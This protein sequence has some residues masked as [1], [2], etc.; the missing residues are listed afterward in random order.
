MNTRIRDF[1]LMNYATAQYIRKATPE[2]FASS[3]AA[4]WHD[5]GAG[6]IDVDGLSC[7]VDGDA[8]PMIQYSHDASICLVATERGE[9][10]VATQDDMDTLPVGPDLSDEEIE[11]LEEEK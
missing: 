6:V 3:V 5:G 7:Y 8:Y 1:D 11:L 9:F 4:S 2:E 10:R